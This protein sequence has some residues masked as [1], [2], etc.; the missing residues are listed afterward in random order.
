MQSMQLEIQEK[1][2]FRNEIAF[3]EMAAVNWPHRVFPALQE[4][5]CPS[6]TGLRNLTKDVHDLTTQ[7]TNIIQNS[8]SFRFLTDL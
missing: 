8:T 3:D 6:E 4:T 1:K 5:A 7:S 2:L